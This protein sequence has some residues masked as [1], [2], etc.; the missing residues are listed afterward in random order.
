M[1]WGTIMADEMDMFDGLDDIFA[2]ARATAPEPTDYLR[3]RV[4]TDAAQVQAGFEQLQPV[5][6]GAVP[7]GGW[8]RQVAN[9]LGGWAGLG[10]L[11]TACAA[12]IWIGFAPPAIWPDPASLVIQEDSGFDLFQSE[13]MAVLMAMGEG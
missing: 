11:A 10:G 4:L 12:G 13:E 3:R 2:V 9:A 6:S 1:T 7:A 8:F 5:I